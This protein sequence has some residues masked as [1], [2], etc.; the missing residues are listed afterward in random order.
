M[1][2]RLDGD[3]LWFLL[4]QTGSIDK[5]SK[6]LGG[7]N[8]CSTDVVAHGSKEVVF[9]F[10]VENLPHPT[11]PPFIVNRFKKHRRLLEGIV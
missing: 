6:R 11:P 7:V 3:G 4:W 2:I 9:D 5:R 10:L 8:S 1:I